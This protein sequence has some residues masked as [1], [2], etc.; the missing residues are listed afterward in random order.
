MVVMLLASQSGRT[1]LHVAS[2]KGFADVVELLIHDGGA[3]VNARD[4]VCVI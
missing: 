4:M 1:A 3:D 2:V